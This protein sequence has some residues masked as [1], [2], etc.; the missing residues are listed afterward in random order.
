MKRKTAGATKTRTSGARTGPAVKSL[1]TGETIA[2][3]DK[4]R[5]TGA[6]ISRLPDEP[7]FREVL[8]TY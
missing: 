2:H 8:V 5:T 7:S 1:T 3:A 4:T 6:T